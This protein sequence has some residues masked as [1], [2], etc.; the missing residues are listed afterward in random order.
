MKNLTH[1]SAWYSPRNFANE[2]TYIYGTAKEVD[3]FFENYVVGDANCGWGCTMNHKS[4]ENA[5]SRCEKEARQD[6]N[7]HKNCAEISSIAVASVA[8]MTPAHE[9]Y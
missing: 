6:R 5:I 2:G 8:E 9:D 4:E 1:K 3:E 7:R